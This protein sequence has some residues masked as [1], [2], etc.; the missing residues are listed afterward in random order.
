MAGMV[1]G[2]VWGKGRVGEG[3]ENGTG[4]AGEGR[5]AG[6]LHNRTPVPNQSLSIRPGPVPW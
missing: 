4:T 6:K 2:S 3:R 5:Q 1:G